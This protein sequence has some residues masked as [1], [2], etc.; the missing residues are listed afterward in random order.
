MRRPPQLP[1][2]EH[3]FEHLDAFAD[4][5]QDACPTL[6]GLQ[7]KIRRLG[8]RKVPRTVRRGDSTRPRRTTK[9]P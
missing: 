6:R 7:I 3:F 4:R 1:P 5:I 9:D 8:G 2:T